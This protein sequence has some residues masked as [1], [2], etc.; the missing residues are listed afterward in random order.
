MSN[1]IQFRR[2]GDDAATSPARR[3]DTA[4]L[5]QSGAVFLAG[6][7]R[8]LLSAARLFVFLPLLWLRRPLRIVL[9]LALFGLFL[10]MPMIFF[11]MSDEPRRMTLLAYA[12]GGWFIGLLLLWFY[13]AL[14]LRLSPQPIYLD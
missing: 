5:R 12:G 14:L 8:L 11:G 1:V 10:A 13:D 9:G 4:R 3:I 2:R 7:A 6:V